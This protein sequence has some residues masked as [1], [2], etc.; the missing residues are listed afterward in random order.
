M[1]HQYVPIFLVMHFVLF[2]V[3][4]QNICI[5][6]LNDTLIKL[7]RMHTAYIIKNL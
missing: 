1:N 5:K 4:G 2:L 3:L 6:W 7:L